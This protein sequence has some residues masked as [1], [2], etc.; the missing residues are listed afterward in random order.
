MVHS[1][2]YSCSF[3]QTFQQRTPWFVLNPIHFPLPLNCCSWP[4][5]GCLVL[6]L[7]HFSISATGQYDNHYS[8]DFGSRVFSVSKMEEDPFYFYRFSGNFSPF[9]LHKKIG[10]FLLY[11]CLEK[12]P[13]IFLY[14]S[15]EKYPG[16]N[17][18][19]NPDFFL[20]IFRWT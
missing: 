12:N 6:F 3:D 7:L 2:N 11:L 14:K 9:L 19:E 18:K 4:F 10:I 17:P 16:K 20:D 1:L 8:L 5:Q 13:P 15:G